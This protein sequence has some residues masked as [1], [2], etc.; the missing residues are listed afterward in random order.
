M[1]WTRVTIC[2]R[3]FALLMREKA[4]DSASPS[5]LITLDQ[6]GGIPGE[7][8][9]PFRVIKE[10]RATFVASAAQEARRPLPRWPHRA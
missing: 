4:S 8:I 5:G 1:F 3:T 6:Q 9:P 2:P 10:K 7:E